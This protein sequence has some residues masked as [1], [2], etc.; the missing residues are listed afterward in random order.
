MPRGDLFEFFFSVL[1]STEGATRFADVTAGIPV[2]FDINTGEEYLDS[3][4]LLYID[5]EVVSSLRIGASLKGKV[6]QSPQVT[7]S[8]ESMEAALQE[9]LRLQT[10]LRSGALPVSFSV[11]S[12]DTI[13]PTL[14]IGFFDGAMK[15]VIIAAIVVFV[16]V[17]IRYRRVKIALPLLL[18]GLSEVI[19]I[20]GIASTNDTGIWIGALVINL[21]LIVTAW[22]KKHEIDVYAWIGALI[23]PLIGMMSWTIDLPALAGIIAV[24]GTGV[25]HQIIIADEALRGARRVYGIREQLK[26]AF[27]IIVGAAATTIFAML[28]LMFVGVGLIRGFAITTIVGV[29][30]GILITRP[31]Y[32][33]IV[34]RL[35]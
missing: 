20:L 19:I 7:G 29:M 21:L 14:G 1:I 2:T 11:L 27:F 10:I 4:L 6:I 22:M 9:K 8:E 16:I 5:G 28:P 13:S 24:I 25:D 31:A 35:L 18:V 12:V 23:V 30:V 34:E 3:S 17:F 26:K 33:R 32:A 15:A